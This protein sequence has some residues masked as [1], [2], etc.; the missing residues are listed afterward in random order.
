MERIRL[1]LHYKDD[2]NQLTL[3]KQE[4]F[5]QPGKGE[6]WPMELKD[7]SACSYTYEV[8]YVM[9]NG[10]ERKSGLISS[11]DTFLVI[12]SVPPQ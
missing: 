8:G 5:Q 10:F 1:N 3:D 11:T 7:P 9:K 12:S 6:P 2:G 4:I